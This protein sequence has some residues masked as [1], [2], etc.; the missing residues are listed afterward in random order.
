MSNPTIY[1]AYRDV[2]DYQPRQSFE[3]LD[4]VPPDRAGLMASSGHF[5]KS[6]TI[7][8]APGM[9]PVYIRWYGFAANARHVELVTYTHEALATG[10][11][12]D[13]A[14]RMVEFLKQ[15]NLLTDPEPDEGDDYDGWMQSFEIPR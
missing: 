9:K 1:V 13:I 10:Q 14:R 12:Q 4:S 2:E 5:V 8:A 15:N 7:P 11:V 6:Q 3:A